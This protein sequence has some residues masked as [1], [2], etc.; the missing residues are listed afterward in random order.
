M[1]FVLTILL[2]IAAVVMTTDGFHAGAFAQARPSTTSRPVPRSTAS[3][4]QTVFQQVNA[5]RARQQL[6]MLQ[7][8]ERLA[9]QAHQHSQAL[10]TSSTR[11]G[12]AGFAQRLTAVAHVLSWSSAAENVAYAQ[13]VQDPT[14]HAVQGWLSSPAH[15]HNLEGPFTLTGIGVARNARGEVA[16]TQIFLKPR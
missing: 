8:E 7:W 10:L 14:T 12:H 2:A 4:E 5:S 16:F 9:Q 11:V 13:G 15:R 3:L 6:P 1:P